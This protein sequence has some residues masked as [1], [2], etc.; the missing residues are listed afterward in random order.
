MFDT[1]LVS[2]KSGAGDVVEKIYSNLQEAL[3]AFAKKKETEKKK[4]FDI[5]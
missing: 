3:I 1:H 2:L 5:W 4:S